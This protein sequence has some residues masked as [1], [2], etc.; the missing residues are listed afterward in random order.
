MFFS[1]YLLEMY[2]FGS[3]YLAGSV[4]WFINAAL[5]R[6]PLKK[7]DKIISMCIINVFWTSSGFWSSKCLFDSTQKIWSCLEFRLK[8][9]CTCLCIYG[10]RMTWAG[11]SFLKECSLGYM[12]YSWVMCLFF[13]GMGFHQL[14]NCMR[15]LG[16]TDLIFTRTPFGKVIIYSYL[17]RKLGS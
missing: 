12:L 5:Y 13:Q 16:L 4:I 8:A 7:W 10:D 6:K 2:A 17:G 3:I 14:Q 15:D 11:W 1:V 9:K